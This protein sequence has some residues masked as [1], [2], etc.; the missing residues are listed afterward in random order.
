VGE[1]SAASEEQTKGISQISTAVTEMDKVTQGNAASAE[2]SASASEELFAQAK[3]LADM[4][5]ILKGIVHGSS[6]PGMTGP[7]PEPQRAAAPIQA[8]PRSDG[9][10][11]AAAAPRAI[12]RHAATAPASKG[13]S[14]T[15]AE[16]DWAPRPS[17]RPEM[18]KRKNGNPASRP[19]TILPLTDEELRDF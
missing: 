19:E 16:R 7:R 5:G 6:G 17:T 11:P 13:S 4:V 8:R 2:E 10:L 14:E 1:V 18:E 12:A 3:E 15:T 9:R